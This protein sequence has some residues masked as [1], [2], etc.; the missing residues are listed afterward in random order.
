[1]G[2]IEGGVKT[3]VVPASCQAELDLRIVPP[4]GCADAN[5]LISEIVEQAVE[6]VDGARVS[7]EN[8]GLQRP[9][10]EAPE[11]SPLILGI[12]RAF[13]DVTGQEIGIGGADGHEAYTDASITSVLTA[14]PHCTVFGPGSTDVAHTVDEYVDAADI[15]LSYEV[16]S[17]L[18]DLMVR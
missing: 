10:V 13:E 14:N 8:L 18:V 2:R 7:V 3:N 12:Q 1:V 11:N 16:L 17:R 15:H 4:L 9:P 6:R 5:E